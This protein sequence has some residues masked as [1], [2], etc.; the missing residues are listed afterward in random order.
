MLQLLKKSQIELKE[1]S[2]RA[3][4]E[5]FGIE[6]FEGSPDFYSR[7]FSSLR[8]CKIIENFLKKRRLLDTK[9]L[10]DFY[11]TSSLSRPLFSCGTTSLAIRLSFAYLDDII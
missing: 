9:I 7:S 10:Y 2:G 11:F 5:L 8:T 1:K 4:D 6:I 3:E